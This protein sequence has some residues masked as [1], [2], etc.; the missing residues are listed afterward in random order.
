MVLCSQYFFSLH[1]QTFLHNITPLYRQLLS[2]A[3]Y[4]LLFLLKISRDKTP[5]KQ[6]LYRASLCDWV[7]WGKK[8]LASLR[9]LAFY[10]SVL[11]RLHLP[12]LGFKELIYLVYQNLINAGWWKYTISWL[13]DW[14]LCDQIHLSKLS[15]FYKTGVARKLYLNKTD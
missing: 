9:L 8:F 6:H 2:V 11:P 4:F 10:F 1:P 5:Q 7:L 15:K 13:E 12:G 14:W 3:S